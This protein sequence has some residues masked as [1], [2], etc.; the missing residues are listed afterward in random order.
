MIQPFPAPAIVPLDGAG[1]RLSR[2]FSL[3][4]CL[5]PPLDRWK[6]GARVRA[7][8]APFSG[9]QSKT[10]PNSADSQN[11]ILCRQEIRRRRRCSW[12]DQVSK[13]S[14]NPLHQCL[15]FQPRG[16]HFNFK[17]PVF[18]SQNSVFADP[19]IERR[20]PE[21]LLLASQIRLPQSEYISNSTIRR[22]IRPTNYASR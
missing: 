16:G 20:W 18:A 21:P 11:S 1:A 2:S 17:N 6:T 12:A 7:T 14:W 5:K 3:S 8:R 19:C 10:R 22:K 15:G 9:G 13:I 4:I